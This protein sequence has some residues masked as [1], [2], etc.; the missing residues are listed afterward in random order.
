MRIKLRTRIIIV[1]TILFIPFILSV[2]TSFV[3]FNNMSS[4]GVAI[5]LSGSQRMRTMLI[6]DYAQEVYYGRLEGLNVDNQI[7]ILETELD[8]YL[9]IM[10]GLVY[11]DE[12]Q[13]DIDMYVDEARKLIADNDQS[14]KEYIV[15]NALT[16]KNNINEVVRMYQG[17]YDSKIDAIKTISIGLLIAGVIIFVIAILSV[18]KVI[19]RPIIRISKNM[20]EIAKGDGD[21][22]HSIQVKNKDEIG[23]LAKDFNAFV[24]SLRLIVKD[25][26]HTSDV[27][28]SSTVALDNITDEAEEN[29]QR[30]TS[31]STEIAEGAMDQASHATDTAENLVTLGEGI[32]TIYGLSKNMEELSLSTV[33]INNKSQIS[34][35]QLK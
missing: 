29:A 19:I 32:S 26:S 27:V 34:V 16:I 24:E 31:V 23:D 18:G 5:N 28:A 4:D 21:L 30:M 2:V 35:E 11:G 6:A 10:D 15:A 17:D 12:I 25:I 3:S 1:F 22:T 9:A 20:N 14:S 13:P 7:E 33:E 8:N